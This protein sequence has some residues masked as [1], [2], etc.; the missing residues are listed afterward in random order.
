MY[1]TKKIRLLPTAEQK[2]LFW[3]SSGIARWSYNFFLSY[4]QEKYNEWLKDN[5][6]KKFISESDV[7]KYINNVLKNTTHAWLKEVGSNV[8]KQG[9]KDANNALQR[10]FNKISNYPKYKSKKRSKPSFYVNYET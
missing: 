9:V 6:K 8:M 10:Y 1:L 2:K 3:K 5:T 4:N 7:R